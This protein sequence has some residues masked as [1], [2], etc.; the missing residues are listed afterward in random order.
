MT[1]T[2][3]YL[4]SLLVMVITF[5][6]YCFS[7][8]SQKTT[9]SDLIA[10]EIKKNLPDQ[11]YLDAI[12]EGIEASSH[13]VAVSEEEYE[14][15]FSAGLQERQWKSQQNLIASEKWMLEKSNEKNISIITPSELFYQ[16]VKEGDGQTLLSSS[17]RVRINYLIF[18]FNNLFPESCG[19]KQVFELSHLVPGLSRGMT[20]M[21]EGEIRKIYIH[22]KYAYAD[23]NTFDPNCA[24]EI[25]VELLN[26]L[27]G[28][29]D[30]A[31][32]AAVPTTSHSVLS[33]NHLKES[34]TK[35]YY[36]IGWR[37]WNHLKYGYHLFNKEEL[38]DSLRK[39]Q[40]LENFSEIDREVNRI[41]WLIY[42]Q[43]IQDQGL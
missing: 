2:K 5:F 23:S 38:M 27:P 21:K 25:I 20:E 13:N 40:L 36:V 24:I 11:K 32:L 22:P 16:V 7:E 8:S 42:Q 31:S 33:D 19:K 29:G 39:E 17:V 15:F 3:R 6:S 35:K 18:K 30:I 12:I 1:S 26:I 28:S 43:R 34:L 37:L 10:Y 14:A 9:P 41:H 4:F